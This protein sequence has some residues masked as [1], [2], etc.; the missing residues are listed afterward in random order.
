MTRGSFFLKPVRTPGIGLAKQD[1]ATPGGPQ[2]L[3]PPAS[4]AQHQQE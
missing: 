4:R 1:G 2:H 3:L